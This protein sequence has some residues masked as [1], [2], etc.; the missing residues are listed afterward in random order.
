MKISMVLIIIP[1]ATVLYNADM[2]LRE[3]L[4]SMVLLPYPPFLPILP[5]FYQSYYFY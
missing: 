2:T 5:V 1:L 3:L 4:I